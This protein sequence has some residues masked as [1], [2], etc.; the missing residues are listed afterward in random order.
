MEYYLC[1]FK[2]DCR[3]LQAIHVHDVLVNGLVKLEVKLT[4]QLHIP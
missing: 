2:K 3:Q 4:D 1:S